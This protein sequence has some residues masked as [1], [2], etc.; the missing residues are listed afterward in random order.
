[1]SSDLNEVLPRTEENSDG[2]VLENTYEF[3]RQKLLAHTDKLSIG[4]L[5]AKQSKPVYLEVDGKQIELPS[6]STVVVG[7]RVTDE[8][9]EQPDVALNAF[10]AAEKGV[11]R[12]HAR[13]TRYSNLICISDMGSSNGTFVNGQRLVNNDTRILHNGDEIQF[14]FLKVKVQF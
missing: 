8:S 4:S 7:R 14:S 11:S 13:I 3:D 6:Q 2:L 12:R 1:M 9:S 5:L 10:D